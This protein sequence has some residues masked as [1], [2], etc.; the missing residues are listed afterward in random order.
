MKLKLGVLKILAIWAS[1]IPNH[2]LNSDHNESNEKC[3]AFLCMCYWRRYMLKI[4]S[5]NDYEEIVGFE[6]YTFYIYEKEK[7]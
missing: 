7:V 5:F 6:N 2:V 4:H 3:Q 1:I